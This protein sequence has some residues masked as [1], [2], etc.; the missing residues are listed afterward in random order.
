M[1]DGD[2]TGPTAGLS[3]SSSQTRCDRPYGRAD[4]R[5]LFLCALFAAANGVIA[6]LVRLDGPNVPLEVRLLLPDFLTD[7]GWQRAW[8]LAAFGF[9]AAYAC[10]WLIGQCL[11]W[12][13][14]RELPPISAFALACVAALA[15]LSLIGN[16]L[17]TL[18][19]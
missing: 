11:F 2:A 16:L 4:R 10:V 18:S 6:G 7:F 8:Q 12:T 1:T 14:R 19:L 9:P 15:L 5:V 3:Y 17:Y 13:S